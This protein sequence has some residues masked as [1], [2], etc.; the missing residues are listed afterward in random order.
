MRKQI[1]N[2]FLA[3]HI[4]NLTSY[5]FFVLIKGGQYFLHIGKKLV[6]PP[7]QRTDFK[8]KKKHGLQ[9]YYFQLSEL[10][11]HTQT[12]NSLLYQQP[13]LEAVEHYN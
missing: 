9:Q 10:A 1:A 5:E 13:C 7:Y 11:S 3:K 6:I 2:R 12:Q 8:C 4:T